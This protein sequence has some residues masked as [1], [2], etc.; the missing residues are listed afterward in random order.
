M[1]QSSDALRR[2]GCNGFVEEFGGNDVSLDLVADLIEQPLFQPLACGIIGVGEEHSAETNP[3]A[4][5]LL[6]RPHPFHGEATVAGQLT[7]SVNG[8]KVLEQRVVAAGNRAQ[9]VAE[10]GGWHWVGCP[11]MIRSVELSHCCEAPGP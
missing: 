1:H 5:G 6:Q 8:A 4:D 2:V 7:V 3:A 9:T 11:R 10:A